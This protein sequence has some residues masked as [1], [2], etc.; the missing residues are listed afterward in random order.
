MHLELPHCRPKVHNVVDPGIA[1]LTQ[2]DLLEDAE[3]VS[4]PRRRA[5]W[6]MLSLALS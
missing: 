6:G 5:V 4:R 1:A 2:C 3:G